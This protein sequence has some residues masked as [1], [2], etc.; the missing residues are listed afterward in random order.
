MKTLLTMMIFFGLLSCASTKAPETKPKDT[1]END[2]LEKGTAEKMIPKAALTKVFSYRQLRWGSA[3]SKISYRLGKPLAIFANK[4][5][6][7]LTFPSTT[8]AYNT[9][10][11]TGLIDNKLV[12]LDINIVDTDECD[13]AVPKWRK[14]LRLKYGPVTEEKNSYILWK[15]ED[16]SIVVI[17]QGVKC[18]IVY[19]RDAEA[20]R[21]VNLLV[22]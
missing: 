2:T 11:T 6:K 5:L 22:E 21:Q 9:T 4:G 17:E 15:I 7:L 20:R 1:M 16:G 12:T 13:E 18:S 19:A 10:V 3:E 8:R 14:A